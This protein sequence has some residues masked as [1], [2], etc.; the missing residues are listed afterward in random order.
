M[1]DYISKGIVATK[2]TSSDTQLVDVFTKALSCQNLITMAF[3]LDLVDWFQKNTQ[4]K[5]TRPNKGRL[6]SGKHTSEGDQD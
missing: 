1:R 3:N 4:V 2:F 5:E 6:V